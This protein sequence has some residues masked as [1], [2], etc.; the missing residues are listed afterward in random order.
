MPTECKGFV[1]GDFLMFLP[2]VPGEDEVIP[3]HPRAQ[4]SE[5]AGIVAKTTNAKK[6]NPSWFDLPKIR[7]YRHR[8]SS[9]KG[10]EPEGNPLLFV[11]GFG[12]SHRCFLDRTKAAQ[13]LH[14]LHTRLHT[15]W[16]SVI[17]PNLART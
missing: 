11:S 4:C 13:A 7:S 3:E 15:G 14:S 1:I 10:R 2:G 8:E 6:I 5:A 17:W 9:V 12:A 16:A